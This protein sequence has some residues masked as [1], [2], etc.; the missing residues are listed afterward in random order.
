M[1]RITSKSDGLFSYI[2]KHKYSNSVSLGRIRLSDCKLCLH[3][4]CFA[5]SMTLKYKQQQNSIK[6]G[7]EE[8]RCF[9]AYCAPKL[10]TYSTDTSSLHLIVM[11][12]ARRAEH[13]CER[14]AALEMSRLNKSETSCRLLE[15]TN[16]DTTHRASYII[17]YKLWPLKVM[18]IAFLAFL[19]SLL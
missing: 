19:H 6:T 5:C 16:E 7:T 2:H 12:T 3:A 11:F 15:H 14:E 13:R 1:F 4:V 10:D 18:R 8:V 9:A 17:K